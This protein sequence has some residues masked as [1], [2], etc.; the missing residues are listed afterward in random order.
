MFT[1]TARSRWFLDRPRHT[2]SLLTRWRPVEPRSYRAPT[3]MNR[4]CSVRP[5][6]APRRDT[7]RPE[8]SRGRAPGREPVLRPEGP[9]A[10]RPGTSP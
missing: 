7:P 10:R 6:A 1:I 5:G 2:P 9:S 3:D 8:L 4:P